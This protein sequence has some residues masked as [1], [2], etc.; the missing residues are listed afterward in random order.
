MMVGYDALNRR[1][2]PADGSIPR[3][4]EGGT[5]RVLEND[6]TGQGSSPDPN[7]QQ[8]VISAHLPHDGLT[9]ELD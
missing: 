2:I 6:L 1:R 5:L 7:V 9:S 8:P 3:H 4:S